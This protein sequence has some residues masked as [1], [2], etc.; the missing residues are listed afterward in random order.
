[1]V[2]IFFQQNKRRSRSFIVG[3]GCPT[4][5]TCLLADLGIFDCSE[6][7]DRLHI[8]YEG[9]VAYAANHARAIADLVLAAIMRGES[10]D[11]V[12]LDDWMPRDSDKQEVFDLLS[13]AIK[14]LSPGH[15]KQMLD[16]Q[17]KNV[18]SE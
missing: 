12:R 9:E 2:G 8:P 16:W 3:V 6:I 7:L 4:D 10:P 14:Q 17:N 1:M 11:F 13:I 5:T 15:Q 18:E